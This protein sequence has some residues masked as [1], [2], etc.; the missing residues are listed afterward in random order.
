MYKEGKWAKQI[1]SLQDCEGKWGCFHSLSQFYG[2]SLTTEQALRRLE[3]LGFSIEDNNIQ[4]AVSYMEDCLAGKRSIPDRREKVSDWDVFSRLILATWI[5]RFTNDSGPANLVAGQWAEVISY[6]FSDGWYDEA[7]YLK[8]YRS[9]LKPQY[10]R[11]NGF[12][13]FYPVSLVRGCMD[14]V[15]ERTMVQYLLKRDA[16]IYYIY[17]RNLSRFPDCFQSREASR[18]LG[19]IELLANYSSAKDQ[20][21]FIAEWL[22]A[23]RSSNGKWDM[24]KSVNDKVYFPLSD[25][26]RRREVREFD[27]TERIER[28]LHKIC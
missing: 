1:L 16:G 4:R 28:L 26:W 9:V 18:Y 6:A 22:I 8:A 2:S 23:H 3:I 19:A 12:A 17:D 5:R 13:M 24:G 27:C 20:L 25:D 10:G 11:I 7:K 15:T 21:G 14:D